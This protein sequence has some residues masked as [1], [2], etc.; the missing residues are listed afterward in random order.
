MKPITERPGAGLPFLEGLVL[1]YWIFPRLVKQLGRDGSHRL[2][3][4]ESEKVLRL[5]E[6]V[7]SERVVV[8]VLIHRLR[9]LE[10]SSRCWSILQT[11]EHV[12][13]VSR[14]MVQTARSLEQGVVPSGTVSTA[15]VKPQSGW[16]ASDWKTRWQQLSQ[17][18]GQALSSHDYVEAKTNQGSQLR[19]EHPWFGPLTS[20]EWRA[21]VSLHLRIHRQ[22]IEAIART[23]SA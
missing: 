7:P 6:S 21:L 16:H 23:F 13:T 18:I 11:L 14:L 12:D 17:D 2:W 22:Q 8:P 3:T 10:D 9:G 1:R 19:Y 15:D 5:V 4:H 20:V